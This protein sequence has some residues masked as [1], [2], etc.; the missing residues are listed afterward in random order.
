[1][2]SELDVAANVSVMAL[3]H[4]HRL[5]QATAS[6]LDASGYKKHPESQLSGECVSAVGTNRKWLLKRCKEES[7]RR[8]VEGYRNTAS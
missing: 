6:I 3:V 8:F 2:P 5:P 1:L 4:R 7:R